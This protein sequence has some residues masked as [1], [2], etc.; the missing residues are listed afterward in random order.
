M[1][2]T[3]WNFPRHSQQSKESNLAKKKSYSSV[4][5]GLYGENCAFCLECDPHLSA[6]LYPH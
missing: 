1:R 4:K 5:V 6:K 2:T 3:I